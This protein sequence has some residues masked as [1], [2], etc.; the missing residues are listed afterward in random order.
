MFYKKLFKKIKNVCIKA[1]DKPNNC[2]SPSRRDARN[3]FSPL[4]CSFTGIQSNQH[5]S[6]RQWSEK[7]ESI[8]GKKRTMKMENE[9]EKKSVNR[10]EKKQQRK[11][12]RQ[13]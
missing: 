8:K 5:V 7:Q 13:P 12:R 3:I 4:S 11:R 6:I 10:S 1:C 2:S 9:R